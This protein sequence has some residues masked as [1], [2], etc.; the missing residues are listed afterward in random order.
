M[1]DKC[2]DTPLIP[3]ESSPD[4]EL[5]PTTEAT[6]PQESLESLEFLTNIQI[7]QLNVFWFGYQY[8]WLLVIILLLPKQIQSIVP[9]EYKGTGLAL[10]SIVSGIVNLFAA[11]PF[12]A[13]NDRFTSAFGRR[14]PWILFGTCGM[15]FALF[16]MSPLDSLWFY[17][18][19]FLLM[20]ISSILCSV[21]FVITYAL[22]I[23][24]YLIL[25]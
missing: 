9:E 17:T 6:Q 23:I 19:A 3:H 11:V 7:V 12:G 21:P 4:I 5:S 22:R 1:Q 18:L 20:T 10:V 16:L 25:N 13:L 15:C 14:K 24:S 8:F 2:E